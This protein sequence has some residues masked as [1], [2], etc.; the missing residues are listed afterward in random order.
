MDKYEY[1]IKT[2]QMLE[3]MRCEEYGKAA[4]VADMIDWRRVRSVSMLADV[5]DIYEKNMD[6]GKSYEVLKLAY[7]RAEGSRKIIYRLCSLALKTG[8]ID[9][10]IDFYE[11]FI[12]AAPK[13]PSRHVLQYQL[14]RA[15]KAPIQQQIRELEEFKKAEYVEKWAYELA[16]LYK[17]A[18]MAAECVE[19]C[20]D[21]ILWFSEGKYVY[22]AME[23]KMTY[24]PLTST[25][26]LKYDGSEDD[27]SHEKE[28]NDT[29]EIPDLSTYQ[30]RKVLEDDTVQIISEEV[31]KSEPES[32][33]VEE[34]PEKVRKKLGNT[35]QLGEALKALLHLGSEQTDESE[36]VQEED[37]SDF[38]ETM[39]EIADVAD[40]GLLYNAK[41]IRRPEVSHVD[42]DLEELKVSVVDED[43]VEDEKAG[44]AEE[45]LTD[46]DLV[47]ALQKAQEEEAEAQEEEAEVQEEVDKEQKA[48]AEELLKMADVRQV[49]EE[50]PEEKTE[51]VINEVSEDNAQI[52]SEMPTSH[53]ILS[54]EIQQMIDEIEGVIPISENET[55]EEIHKPSMGMEARTEAD[56]ME[57][58]T[59][60][61]RL[62]TDLSLEE[63]DGEDWESDEV[64][65]DVKSD[66][67]KEDIAMAKYDE[68]EEQLGEFDEV[69]AEYVS[70]SLER[71]FRPHED[72][73]EQDDLEIPEDDDR[74]H[75]LSETAPLSRKETAKL[76]A[77]GKTS[78]IPIDEISDALSISDN[79]FIVHRGYELNPQ[80]GKKRETLT[81]EQ[82]KLFSYFVPVRGMSEQLIDV[83]EQEKNCNNREGTSRTGNLLV[84]GNKGNGKT[85]LAV[86]VV[87]AIQ[88]QRGIRHGKV[89]ILTGEAMN[90]K[91]VS[92]VFD[93]LYG[94][95]LIIE[96]AGKLDERTVA[97]MNKAMEEDTGELLVVLEDQRKPLDRLLTTSREFRKRFTSRLEV[98]VFI[99]DELVTFGQ[100]Y[101]QE[102]GYR[103]DEMGI[104]AL[105]SRIDSMQREDHAVTVAEV[106][107][108][109]D[110]VM[111]KSRK[112]SAKKV[113]GKLFG[114]NKDDADRIILTEK[115][116]L[117]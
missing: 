71:E 28:L 30:R 84:I 29:E 2:K 89:A 38:Q 68:L 59:E 32:E 112:V 99:N 21:L 87:K 5:S 10:A 36:E 100:T 3:F 33:V 93:K 66:S 79:G 58:V 40:L 27:G 45:L 19:E 108:I 94:G 91:K 70:K 115:D 9:E 42:S 53:P 67:S 24:K 111:E 98:P 114:H 88:K 61:I 41:S 50:S 117:A 109:M 69:D 20:D 104:L 1:K 52:E 80:K 101:A 4:E 25:Q 62:Q 107:E 12:Q 16:K 105:Y 39:D 85:V 34:K 15:Q 14:L 73:D 72:F 113:M 51:E 56:N 86:D 7:H 76:I 37:I 116:F 110:E 102:N 35:M 11:E 95:A 31:E 8:N 77:T 65:F 57:S 81:E 18:G 23:L 43:N 83:L 60:Q 74:I 17:E 90:R 49:K 96:K 46:E 97:R 44:I 63:F 6:Y 22:Q 103:I 106:K 55:Q 48:T 64:G 82:K 78:P 75:F 47:E 92:D 13:D 54:P 26:Q